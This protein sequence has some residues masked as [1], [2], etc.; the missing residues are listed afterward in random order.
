MS[1]QRLRDL[2]RDAADGG[3]MAEA[4]LLVER[5]RVGDLT[6]ERLRL[7]AYLGHEPARLA[8][9]REAPAAEAGPA[10]GLILGLKPYGP[11]AF[12]RAAV[13]VAR[14]VA[15]SPD[16]NLVKPLR[17]WLRCMC[18]DHAAIVRRESQTRGRLAN[19]DVAHV[20][21]TFNL[22]KNVVFRLARRA[23]ST[24]RAQLCPPPSA[25]EPD[26]P[27]DLAPCDAQVRAAITL[28]L[29]PWSLGLGDPVLDDGASDGRSA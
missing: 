21:S 3:L 11:P 26:E 1:D 6:E 22:T 14:L 20:G 13:A 19:W 5:V 15:D 29:V 16:A 7:A 27:L 12:I 2:D 25:P 17:A 28:A 4:R 18:A 10:A 9:G 23:S 8:L 24:D